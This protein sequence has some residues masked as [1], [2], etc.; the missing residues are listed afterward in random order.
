[1]TGIMHC[2]GSVFI[3]K[4]GYIL[5]RRYLVLHAIRR[6]LLLQLLHSRE[7][8]APTTRGYLHLSSRDAS[9][10][11]NMCHGNLSGFG[12]LDNPAQCQIA[13]TAFLPFIWTAELAT[14]VC[15]KQLQTESCINTLSLC[16]TADTM[17][18][19][20]FKDIKPQ[21][22]LHRKHITSLLQ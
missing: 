5:N 9:A 20:V 1:M 14:E 18:N 10:Q 19:V 16:K 11:Q 15:R 3:R 7:Q 4:C 13:P 22:V 2:S 6:R 12:A 21:F 8:D 17:K